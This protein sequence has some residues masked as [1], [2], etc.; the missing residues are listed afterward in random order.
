MADGTNRLPAGRQGRGPRAPRP[1]LAPLEPDLR[2][3]QAAIGAHPRMTD[4][5]NQWRACLARDGIQGADRASTVP[6]LVASLSE[7][8][9][10]LASRPGDGSLADL[11]ADERR[12]ATAVARCETAFIAARATIAAAYERRFVQ[13]HRSVLDAIRQALEAADAA[14]PT[15][16][17]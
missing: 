13:D 11:Q 16:P 7:R 14:L 1:L 2:A 8:L 4:V 6:T 9:H 5:T 3:M 12:L 17:P 10:A 15:L